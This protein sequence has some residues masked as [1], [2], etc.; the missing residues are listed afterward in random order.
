MDEKADDQTPL[1]HILMLSGG[2]DSTA[3]ALYMRDKY[4]EIEMET[5]YHT[6][7]VAR[8]LRISDED[9]GISGKAG[10]P[11]QERRGARSFPQDVS[12]SMAL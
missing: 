12:G 4:P 6:H 11:S 9:R 3:L 8:D 2:K 1:R 7:G 5:V 10:P